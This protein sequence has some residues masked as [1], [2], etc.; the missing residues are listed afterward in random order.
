MLL[1]IFKSNKSI[2]G[3]LAIILSVVLW[4]PGFY[5][6][7]DII[8]LTPTLNF[9]STNFLFEP[10]WL[11][12]IV[13]SL[14]VGFQAVFLNFIVNS[15]KVL[16]SNSFLAALFYVLLNGAG[17]VLFS[18]NLILVVNT[19]VL[20]M[21]YSLFKLYGLQNANAT[22]FNL[23]MFLGISFVLHSHFIVL[24]PIAVFTITYV[25]TSNVKDYIILLIGFLVP[26][27]YWLTYLFLNDELLQFITEYEFIQNVA[28]SNSIEKGYYFLV[29]LSVISIAAVFNLITT[30]G[31]NVVKV[32]KLQVIIVFLTLACLIIFLFRLGDYTTIYLI[33]VLPL[34]IVLANLFVNIK[35]RGL[36][37]LGFIILLVSLLLDY[38]L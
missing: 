29:V 1:E 30:I 37:E 32:R 10:R 5:I 38:F 12:I 26:G 7:Q 31:R 22:I 14:L 15:H 3:V 25:R 28:A 11:N 36:A 34:S 23:G 9:N 20:L 24:F 16:K 2:V 4:I 19:F 18:L 6:S 8:E 13:T 27:I 17:L 21:L 33:M 35:R